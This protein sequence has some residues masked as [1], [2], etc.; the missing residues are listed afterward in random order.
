LAL[1]RWYQFAVDENTAIVDGPWGHDDEADARAAFSRYERRVRSETNYRPVFVGAADLDDLV[2]SHAEY[3]RAPDGRL[4]VRGA[5]DLAVVDRRARM[6]TPVGLAPGA[7]MADEDVL[8]LV[9]QRVRAVTVPASAPRVI[10][11]HVRALGELCIYASFAY[12]CNA[13]VQTLGAL[14]HELVLGV[15]FVER[16]RAGVPL[17][18]MN[19]EESAVLEVPLFS[20]LAAALEKDGRYPW[21]KGW[22]LRDH[23]T[24]RPTLGGLV[25]WAHGQGLFADW[26]ARD[27]ARVEW[28]VRSVELT[29]QGEQKWTPPEYDGWE[30]SLQLEWWKTKGRKH[31]EQQRLDNISGLRNVLAHPSIHA[32]AS[33]VDAIRALDQLQ[34]FVWALWPDGPVLP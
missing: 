19:S 33:P 31:W 15:K 5:S 26:L 32:L 10:R 8:V 4:R 2:V 11:D 6:F 25:R 9:Q 3:F 20:I 14:A 13:F 17:T 22:R 29:R 28:S 30:A 18:Q 27:W 16:H 21:R 24:F 7:P 34:D 1:M 23:P 12:D